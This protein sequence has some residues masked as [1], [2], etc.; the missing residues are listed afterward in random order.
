MSD[1]PDQFLMFPMPSLSGESNIDR[2]VSDIDYG[3]T[4]GRVVPESS[5]KGSASAFASGSYKDTAYAKTGFRIQ[6]VDSGANYSG[7]AWAWQ[8][9]GSPRVVTKSTKTNQKCKADS[10]TFDYTYMEV[11][12]GYN[13]FNDWRYQHS[14]ASGV[15]VDEYGYSATCA[16]LKDLERECL[17]YFDP[18]N[19]QIAFKYRN[20]RTDSYTSWTRSKVEFKGISPA[21][22]AVPSYPGDSFAPDRWTGRSYGDD[23]YTGF[24]VC[25]LDDAT[26][27]GA[28]FVGDDI[29]LYTSTDGQYWNLKAKNI[30][31]R[32]A[33]RTTRSPGYAQQIKIARSGN[34]LRIM[35][36]DNIVEY[37]GTSGF[38]GDGEM[39]ETVSTTKWTYRS[40]VSSDRG[41]TWQETDYQ[42]YDAPVWEMD[43]FEKINGYQ[44]EVCHYDIGGCDDIAGTFVFARVHLADGGI[45]WGLS[46]STASTT[47]AWTDQEN[48]YESGN[49]STYTAG[50]FRPRSVWFVRGPQFLHL[51]VYQQN[52]FSYLPSPP[53]RELYGTGNNGGYGL[54]QTLID[55]YNASSYTGWVTL[56]AGNWN[57]TY[58]CVPSFAGG[59]SNGEWV[60]CFG[61]RRYGRGST[62]KGDLVK[63]GFYF[64]VGGWDGFPMSD[65]HPTFYSPQVAHNGS[66][67]PSCRSVLG[68]STEGGGYTEM[69]A[70]N[71]INWAACCGDPWGSTRSEGNTT[72]WDRRGHIAPD[73]GGTARTRTHRTANRLRLETTVTS[74][75]GGSFMLSTPYRVPSWGSPASTEDRSYALLPIDAPKGTVFPSPAG[76]CIEFSIKARNCSISHEDVFVKIRS[77]DFQAAAD[78]TPYYVMYTVVFQAPATDP[79][80]NSMGSN[81]PGTIALIDNNSKGTT[82]ADQVVAAVPVDTFDDYW[83]VRI[84]TLPVMDD[85]RTG[86]LSIVRCRLMAKKEGTT[87]WF[88]SDVD[89]QNNDE[90]TTSSVMSKKCLTV[91]AGAAAGTANQYISWGHGVNGSSMGPGTGLA[92]QSFWRNLQVWSPS[93]MQQFQYVDPEV[94][95]P[96]PNM[97][98]ENPWL[99]PKDLRGQL[100]TPD[101]VLLANGIYMHW[102]AIGAMEEDQW[103]CKPDFQYSAANIFQPSPRIKWRSPEDTATVITSQREMVIKADS[104]IDNATYQDVSAIAFVGTNFKRVDVSFA[105]DTSFSSD[106]ITNTCHFKKFGDGTQKL[107][108]NSAEN[109]VIYFDSGQNLPYP[110]QLIDGGSGR[111][112]M[113]TGK[114]AWICTSLGTGGLLH[115]MY[116]VTRQV[117]TTAF[118]VDM[119]S[120]TLTLTGGESCIIY[121][122]R[123]VCF[124]SDKPDNRHK[125]MKLKPMYET[126]T[127][128][129]EIGTMVAGSTMSTSNIPME[130]NYTDNQQPNITTYRTKGAVRWGFVEGPPQRAVTGM[131][132]GDLNRKREEIRALVNQTAA[133]QRLPIVFGFTQKTETPTSDNVVGHDN[134]M[135]CWA[136]DVG[137]LSNAAW[138]KDSRGIWRNAGD[139]SI[140][141]QE[142]V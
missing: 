17:Y 56:D 58:G 3:I 110:G 35:F 100:F 97:M 113:T 78:S 95:Y 85:D 20:S 27:I 70:P 106:V 8:N 12:G 133:Y 64:R 34:Y 80:E 55:P 9:E 91:K 25:A 138:Y 105:S 86:D 75:S 7:G 21:T 16:Y 137:N 83:T 73:Y 90:A 103:T 92:T 13:G 111:M 23:W 94:I 104:L 19:R 22:G 44:G 40:L 52:T 5:N 115:N 14:F 59:Y 88:I 32:F 128:Y 50:R 10:A 121:V 30:L 117:G 51:F 99:Y 134:F 38:S 96:S 33:V 39:V 119:R 65:R 61:G 57:A 41:A 89:Y 2:S 45:R 47:S 63:G 107:R 132:V 112:G 129:Y 77:E 67:Q 125:Y 37:S 114:R 60:A 120:D 102:G 82:Q 123:A 29:Y 18:S 54:T 24:N 93:D 62:I 139:L 66:W 87:K 49:A 108:V 109:D 127:G 26:L 131:F 98:N 126:A 101:P 72:F 84:V 122:D 135:L 6:C 124:L 116:E 130:W 46:K 42:R 15:D 140:S 53:E 11:D 76:S 43:L 69:D 28:L 136:Q 36:V 81:Y 74:S 71:R 142:C 1:L 4:P 68:W 79:N 48:L 141:L 31:A 118:H